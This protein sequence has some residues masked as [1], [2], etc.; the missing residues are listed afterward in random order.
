MKFSYAQNSIGKIF[1]PLIFFTS[2]S[3]HVVCK[4]LG[5]QIFFWIKSGSVFK[6]FLAQF[7]FGLIKKPRF[8]LGHHYDRYYVL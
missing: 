6:F 5:F 4:A 8:N 7:G 3:L 1:I 2:G